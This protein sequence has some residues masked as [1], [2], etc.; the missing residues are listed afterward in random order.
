[1]KRAQESLPALCAVVCPHCGDSAV[2]QV[3]VVASAPNG[4]AKARPPAG[5]GPKPKSKGEVMD[6][7]ER[8]VGKGGTKGGGTALEC[9]I[10]GET[11]KGLKVEIGGETVWLPKSKLFNVRRMEGGDAVGGAEVLT[12][13]VP[14]WLAKRLPQSA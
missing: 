14:D 8:A 11:D 6:A 12:C 2:V 1:M 13:T 9:V 10:L 4:V 3:V 7:L 5:F